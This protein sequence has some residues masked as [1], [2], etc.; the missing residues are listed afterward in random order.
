MCHDNRYSISVLG[1]E[2]YEVEFIFMP[3]VFELGNIVRV[4]VDL[5]F[6]VPPATFSF[7]H[8]TQ[9]QCV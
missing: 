9:V 4:G 8:A 1:A 6:G 3:L 7:D 5:F 2:S